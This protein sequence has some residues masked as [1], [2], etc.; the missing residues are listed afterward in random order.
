MNSAELILQFSSANHVNVTFDG[1]DSGRLEFVNPV[2]HK[3]REDIRWYVETYGA[4]S[5][6]D[7]DDAEARRIEG[8]LTEIGKALFR[9]V[10]QAGDGEANERFLAFRNSNA[11][12]R[13]ITITAYDSSVLSLPWEL[14][15]DPRGVFL[16]REKP[17]ISVRRRVAGAERG[18]APLRIKPKQQL[19]VLFVISR[20]IDE[21]VSFIDPRSDPEAI[22]DTLHEHA[23][24]RITC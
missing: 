12:Q 14:L 1:T 6:A 24:G 19:H 8:R 5:L 11:T 2:T 21:G 7:P 23:P 22:L 4:R 10:F 13:V 18:R 3:D 16:F 15:H 20:P 9:A 17:H